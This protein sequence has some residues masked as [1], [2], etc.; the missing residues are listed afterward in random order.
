MVY[1]RGDKAQY[2]AWEELGN[3]GWNWDSIFAYDKKGEHFI[4]PTRAQIAKGAT[5]EK[6]A[7]GTDGPLDM[8]FPFSIS[9]SSYHEKASA[10]WKTL[11]IETITD[12]NDGNPHGFDT[13]PMT[14]DPR[15]AL[16]EDSS[17]AYYTPV[18]SRP[19]LKI[20]KGTVKRITW[21]NSHNRAAVA[22]GFEYV[23]PSGKLV[24]IKAKKE[25]VLSASAYRTPLILEGSGVGNPK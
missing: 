3:K 16:R 7:H 15:A 12:L 8:G 21:S 1:I 5:Y 4:P 23:D 22:D 24:A 6:D 25:V 20:I 18:E 9:N 2:D 17:R 13:A 10:T 11:G 19:N 14:L